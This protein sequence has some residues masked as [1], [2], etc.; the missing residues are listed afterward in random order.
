MKVMSSFCKG[1]CLGFSV[2]IPFDEKY[3]DNNRVFC[4]Q[5]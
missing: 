2:K 3:Y 1:I 4:R 5:C